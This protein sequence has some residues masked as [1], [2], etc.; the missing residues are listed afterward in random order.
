[1]ARPGAAVGLLS[2][3]RNVGGDVGTSAAQTTHERR[4]QFRCLR[5]GEHLDQLNPA[6][7]SFIA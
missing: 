4:E 6:V 2:L 1:M 7:R 5:P 3:P